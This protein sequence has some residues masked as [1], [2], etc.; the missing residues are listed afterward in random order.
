[1]Q[2]ANISLLRSFGIFWTFPPPVKTGGYK[3]HAPMERIS[4]L[5]CA[6]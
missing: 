2:P 6:E 3:Y 1:L 4:M 5:S